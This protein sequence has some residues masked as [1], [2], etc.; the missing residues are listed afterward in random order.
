MNAGPY[1]S[2]FF[3]IKHLA[4]CFDVGLIKLIWN[5]IDNE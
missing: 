4:K 1:G 5:V 3:G 2:T